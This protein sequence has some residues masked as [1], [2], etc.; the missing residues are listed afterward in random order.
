MNNAV[1]KVHRMSG[2]HP[3][4]V[5]ISGSFVFEPGSVVVDASVFDDILPVVMSRRSIHLFKDRSDFADPREKGSTGCTCEAWQ[6]FH[7]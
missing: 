1:E 2:G 3:Y 5:Q 4:I 6:P 7:R